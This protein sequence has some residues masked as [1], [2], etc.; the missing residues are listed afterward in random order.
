MSN[1]SFTEIK[2]EHSV[3]K[4]YNS[5][6]ECFLPP[7][8][9]PNQIKRLVIF[10][11]DNTLFYSPK[12]NPQ[13]FTDPVIRMLVQDNKYLPLMNWWSFED[14]LLYT[15]TSSL[16][17]ESEEHHW[18]KN[19]LDAARQAAQDPECI[20]IILT[21]RKSI[22]FQESFKL[23]PKFKWLYVN[24]KFIF[25]AVCLK[26]DPCM[27]TFEYKEKLI[28]DFLAAY[29]KL[30]ELTL[31][32]DRPQHV[33]RFQKLLAKK[34]ETY[35]K[36]FFNVIPVTQRYSFLPTT[37]ELI[38][39]QNLIAKNADFGSKVSKYTYFAP[40]LNMDAVR[41]GFFLDF[42][43]QR[44]V[45]NWTASYFNTK[46]IDIKCL[47]QYP[48]MIPLKTFGNTL[49]KSSIIQLIDTELLTDIISKNKDQTPVT[50]IE[51]FLRKPKDANSHIFKFKITGIAY[52]E[53]S[54]REIPDIMYRVAPLK[55]KKK[56]DNTLP[57]FILVGRTKNE[58]HK[59]LA[60]F[61]SHF[62]KH[63]IKWQT[64]FPNAPV[65]F[66][67]FGV[68]RSIDFRFNSGKR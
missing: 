64:N 18:N 52:N 23:L 26:N 15:L 44:S 51:K 12:P 27:Q 45:N 21:G 32:E 39:V 46:K 55:E 58:S 41:M 19:V 66:S 5:I 20:S 65:I 38:M 14:P 61:I 67:T 2:G 25:N 36:C 29:P 17:S 30:F 33:I 59:K 4:E 35:H 54:H 49:T 47:N 8:L 24:D 37:K 6:S 50:K 31:F 16:Q 13:L 56:I 48:M 7:K 9:Y 53:I 11:F 22:Y 1:E 10:D 40:I 63:T 42:R 28:D 43:T 3:L 60:A 68:S 57:Q 62:Q 34:E